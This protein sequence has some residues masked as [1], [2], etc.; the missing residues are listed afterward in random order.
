MDENDAV[1]IALAVIGRHHGEAEHQGG[2]DAGNGDN[3]HPREYF[4]RKAQKTR[5]IGE[6]MDADT[7]FFLLYSHFVLMRPNL[8]RS[9]SSI[10]EPF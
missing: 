2:G 5:R 8:F 6:K 10:P 1:G 9:H 4:P 3:R 7:G